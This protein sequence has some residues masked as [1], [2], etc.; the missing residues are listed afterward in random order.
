MTSKGSPRLEL[1]QGTLDLFLLRTLSA[2]PR[3]GH[4]IAKHIQRT[5]E[6][7]LRSD[8]RASTRIISTATAVGERDVSIANAPR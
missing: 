7:L 5:S 3:H 1:L 6:E 4:A 2:G 8:G